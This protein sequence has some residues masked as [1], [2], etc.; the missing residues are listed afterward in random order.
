M[1]S[2]PGD[3]VIVATGNVGHLARYCDARVWTTVT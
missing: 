3:Q 2:Q 1:L